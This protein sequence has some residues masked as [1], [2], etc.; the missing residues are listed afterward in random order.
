MPLKTPPKLNCVWCLIFLLS[1]F[2]R[3]RLLLCGEACRARI[4]VCRTRPQQNCEGQLVQ[5][6]KAHRSAPPGKR[7][8]EPERSRGGLGVWKGDSA[9][10]A[11]PQT[12]P[13]P[14]PGGHPLK[15]KENLQYSEKRLTRSQALPAG[16]APTQSKEKSS[17]LGEAYHTKSFPFW[18]SP[19]ILPGGHPLKVKQNL[20]Y[21]GKLHIQSRIF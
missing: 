7:I 2:F 1:A 15:V 18:T 17:M 9:G 21:L 11:R 14:P 10:A 16:R 13:F 6:V 4:P 20:Q 8:F 19:S 12:I 3:R 5:A